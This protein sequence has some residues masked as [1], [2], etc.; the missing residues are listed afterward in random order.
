M[1]LIWDS[2]EPQTEFD[3]HWRDLAQRVAENAERERELRYR[4]TEQWIA[5]VLTI[6]LAVIAAWAWLEMPW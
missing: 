2:E 3:A 1:S 6:G 4:A 5:S